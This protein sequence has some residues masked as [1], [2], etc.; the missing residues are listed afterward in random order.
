MRC[1]CRPR[2]PSRSR[3][4][5]NAPGNRASPFGDRARRFAWPA[6]GTERFLGR[7]VSKFPWKESG[8]NA[9]GSW[10]HELARARRAVWCRLGFAEIGRPCLNHPGAEVR[11]ILLRE[12]ES[13]ASITT[14]KNE[15]QRSP[16]KERPSTFLG[17]RTV[18]LLFRQVTGPKSFHDG[19]V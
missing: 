9:V 2:V 5:G 10:E 4:L 13:V 3:F 11:G 18:R 19:G 12:N 8:D 7:R 1:D 6:R 14:C 16:W 15:K 17:H